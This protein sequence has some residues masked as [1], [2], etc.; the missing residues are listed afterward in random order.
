MTAQDTPAVMIVFDDRALSS[1]RIGPLHVDPES[2]WRQPDGGHNYI[3]GPVIAVAP[4]G[5]RLVRESENG[6]DSLRLAVFRDDLRRLQRQ[7]SGHVELGDHDYPCL[8]ELVA[9]GS[10]EVRIRFTHPTLDVWDLD[11]T[12]IDWD[13]VASVIGQIDDVERV[14]GPLSGYCPTCPKPRTTYR[15]GLQ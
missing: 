15:P 12:A 2:I 10:D 8:I 13:Q 1:L 14:L 6:F 7:R 9:D 5:T 4:D 11:I 3:F